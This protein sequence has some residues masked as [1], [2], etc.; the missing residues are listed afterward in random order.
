MT[1]AVDAWPRLACKLSE[2]ENPDRVFS[3]GDGMNFGW[4][5][6]DATRK[7]VKLELRDVKGKTLWSHTP[8]GLWP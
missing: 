2:H 8:Q 6:V 1:G 4:L 5:E 7:T 3:Y